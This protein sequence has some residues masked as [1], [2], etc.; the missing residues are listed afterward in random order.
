MLCSNSSSVDEISYEVIYFIENFLF[1]NLLIDNF[2]VVTSVSIS[3][4][5]LLLW[6]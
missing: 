3:P 4:F 5:I 1:Y 6:Y 2:L